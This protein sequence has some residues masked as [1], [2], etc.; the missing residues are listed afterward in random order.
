MRRMTVLVTD[1]SLDESSAVCATSRQPLSMV[2][3]CPRF[4]ILVISVTD[5][6]CFW[7]L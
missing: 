6:L 4:G 1:E 3:E 7:R 2:S 5:S